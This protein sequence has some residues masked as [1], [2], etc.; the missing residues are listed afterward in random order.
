[1]NNSVNP[2]K[3]YYL[4]AWKCMLREFLGWPESSVTDW[5]RQTGK[6]RFLDDPDDIF[7]HENPQYWITN[8]LI[9]EEV[10]ARLSTLEFIELQ[11]RLIAAFKDENH[12][13]FP[14]D[15]D[16]GPYRNKLERILNEYGAHLPERS[17]HPQE[18]SGRLR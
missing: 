7:Y 5:V 9:P 6:A 8:I 1:M 4:N 12:F 17:N 15:T 3:E 10:K 13:S 18:A 11:H 14:D 16:W 2:L